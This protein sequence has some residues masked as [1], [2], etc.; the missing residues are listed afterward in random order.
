MKTKNF[1]SKFFLGQTLFW[2]KKILGQ[3]FLGGQTNFS[4]QKIFWVKKFWGKNFWHPK[5]FWVKNSWVLK[6][7]C[8]KKTGGYMTPPPQENSR[9]KILL[10]RSSLSKKI[11]L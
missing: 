9:V 1:G 11:F 6:I 2:V 4:G 10:G 8:L 3:I 5:K 7:F